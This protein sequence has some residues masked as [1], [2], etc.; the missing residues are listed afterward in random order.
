[1]LV[2]P[3]L[4][5]QTLSYASPEAFLCLAPQ[6]ARW[7][8]TGDVQPTHSMVLLDGDQNQRSIA[9]RSV[10]SYGQQRGLSGMCIPPVQQ[11]WPRSQ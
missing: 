8:Y 3:Q 11:K 1:M 9:A 10:G 6:A 2:V 4:N 7:C 5:P